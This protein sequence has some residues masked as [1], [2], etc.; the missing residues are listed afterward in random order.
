MKK[1]LI[2]LAILAGMV[3]VAWEVKD[4]LLEHPLPLQTPSPI[5]QKAAPRQ[6]PQQITAALQAKLR[7][8]KPV[9]IHE[10]ELTA[11][12]VA[13]VSSRQSGATETLVQPVRTRIT[14]Q[15][16]QM[17]LQLHV[18]ELNPET[19]PEELAPLWDAIQR[20][21]KTLGASRIPV[22]VEFTPRVFNG[23][24]VFTNDLQ[25]RVAN[26]ALSTKTLNTQLQPIINNVL[27]SGVVPARA[28]KIELGDGQLL[29]I[30]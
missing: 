2:L 16:V 27:Q 29:F 30:P 11:A 8:G 21:L 15:K 5:P 22:T 18:E 6:T 10:E 28:Q 25:V 3:W 13:A 24:V 17:E 12:L 26:V 4:Y 7:S 19:I 1:I 20:Y 14:P 9:I 23:R